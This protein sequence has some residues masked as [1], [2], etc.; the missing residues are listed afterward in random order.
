[1]NNAQSINTGFIPDNSN[2]DQAWNAQMANTSI[3]RQVNDMTAAGINPMALY[4]R[5]SFGGSA[6]PATATQTSA[7]AYQ[8]QSMGTASMIGAIGG[9]VSGAIGGVSKILGLFV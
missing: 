2:S 5:G 7:Q 4:S 6:T 8:S 9:V 3:Q 1:M